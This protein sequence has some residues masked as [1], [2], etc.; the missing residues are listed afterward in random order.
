MW[1]CK[2]FNAIYVILIDWI[3]VLVWNLIFKKYDFRL[4]A[5]VKYCIFYRFKI[6]IFFNFR[7][8]GRNELKEKSREATLVLVIIVCIF[9]GC[10][11]W[12]FVLTL[13]E[14]I[15]GQEKL[16]F[17][18]LIL[19]ILFSKFCFSDAWSPRVLY[20]LARGD[21][22]FGYYKFIDKF[23]DLSHFWQGL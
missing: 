23:R 19:S 17:F 22:F 2:H 6:L 20:V 7:V 18:L 11:F 14:R 10:N 1:L 15:I 4:R 5:Y 13:L 16:V 12:G 21:Q 8:T 9:L 3:I